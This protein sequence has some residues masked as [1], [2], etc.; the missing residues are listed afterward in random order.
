MSLRNY[1]LGYCDAIDLSAPEP[2]PSD[3]DSDYLIGYIQ[4]F[5]QNLA[6]QGIETPLIVELNYQGISEP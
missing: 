2:E 3:S 4:G 1:Y 5:D 6:E